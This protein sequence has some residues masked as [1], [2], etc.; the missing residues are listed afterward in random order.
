[1]IKILA[2]EYE[3]RP[4][5][6][7]KALRA[8]LQSDLCEVRFVKADGTKRNMR[9]T[10]LPTFLPEQTEASNVNRTM[11]KEVLQVWDIEKEAWRSFRLDSVIRLYKGEE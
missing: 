4:I 8:A 7:R 2:K 1:M 11:N 3:K 10:L 6:F 5:A 9:C